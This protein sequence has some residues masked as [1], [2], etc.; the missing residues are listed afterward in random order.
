M[1]TKSN[2]IPFNDNNFQLPAELAA[3]GADEDWGSGQSG[4]FPVISIK[5]KVFTI[6][7]GEDRELVTRPDDPDEAASNIEVVIL[8]T[9]KGVARTYYATNYEEGSNEKPDCFS[10]DGIA[11]SSEA[12][13]PQCKQCAICPHAQWGSRIT[14]NGK[15]GKA[16]SEVKRLAVAP[17]GQ[18]NDPMLMRVPPTSLQSW[19]KY[20]DMLRKRGVQPA[21]VV[22]KIG[23]DHSVSHQ[24]LT[25]K[26]VGFIG[27]ELVPEVI[28]SRDSK[29]VMDII[30]Q[31]PNAGHAGDPV[32]SPKSDAAAA[33][34]GRKMAQK[35]AAAAA[36]A[37]DTDSD[38]DDDDAA[39]AAEAKQ[40]AADEAAKKKAA[41]AKQRAADKAKADEAA[42]EKAAAEKAEAPKAEPE[43][44][45]DSELDDLLGDLDD[46]DD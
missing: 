24:M 32:T 11:P 10:N 37:D 26:P 9:H 1:S 45:I 34:D 7:R 42:A 35:A 13:N 36:T 14:E 41:A 12:E 22:T 40:K 43:D 25:F 15:K 3:L 38:D 8:K 39:A 31:G 2:I 33:T 17:A 19:D 6:V 44:D 28:E 21:Q 18:L 23:F 4:G 20:V 30:G 29:V 16:C 5:S 27:P 46:L